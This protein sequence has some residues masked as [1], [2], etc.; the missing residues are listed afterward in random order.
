VSFRRQP[1]PSPG[2]K[3]RGFGFSVCGNRL[4]LVHG[5]ELALMIGFAVSTRWRQRDGR[6][7]KLDPHWRAKGAAE[8]AGDH[9]HRAMVDEAAGGDDPGRPQ[10]RQAETGRRRRGRGGSKKGGLEAGLTPRARCGRRPRHRAKGSGPGPIRGQVS[11][12]A[13]TRTG[14]EGRAKSTAKFDDPNKG[15]THIRTDVLD[16]PHSFPPTAIRPAQVTRRGESRGKESAGARQE[17]PGPAPKTAGAPSAIAVEPQTTK[18]VGRGP[19]PG[20]DAARAP[21]GSSRASRVRRA[22]RRARPLRTGLPCPQLGKLVHAPGGRGSAARRPAAP[23]AFGMAV[24]SADWRRGPWG[25]AATQDGAQRT[26]TRRGRTALPLEALEGNS[27]PSNRVKKQVATKPTGHTGEKRPNSSR[28]IR[29]ARFGFLRVKKNRL[30]VGC[31]F[32]ASRPGR[33]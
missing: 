11:L 22:F 9:R 13:R 19:R 14:R 20:P 6:T 1:F 15:R 29:P 27:P 2:V 30:T 12:G 28:T 10:D 4:F 32:P 16:P 25:Q 24:G 31:E 26:S 18:G 33:V 5:P 8:P 23:Q 7:F 17:A 21:R 3:P